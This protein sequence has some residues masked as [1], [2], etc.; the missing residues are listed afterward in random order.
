[1]KTFFGGQGGNIRTKSCPSFRAGLGKFGQN[2]SHPPKTCFLLHLCL[3]RPLP[4]ACVMCHAVALTANAACEVFPCTHPSRPNTLDR[5]Q[6]PF[7]SLRYD[8]TGNRTQLTSFGGARATNKAALSQ[9]L[10]IIYQL[11]D[12][13]RHFSHWKFVGKNRF[14]WARYSD[15]ISLLRWALTTTTVTD[16]TRLQSDLL[17]SAEQAA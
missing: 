16:L 10:K 12:I 11:M 9:L 13:Q 15:T 6:V 7:S 4:L 17:E 1:M 14:P 3:R 2:I 8:L 5:S